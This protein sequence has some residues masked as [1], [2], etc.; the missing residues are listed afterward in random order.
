[1]A[2][3][4]S[5]NPGPSPETATAA[6]L[7]AIEQLE[8]AAGELESAIDA[9]ILAESQLDMVASDSAD[10]GWEQLDARALDALARVHRAPNGIDPASNGG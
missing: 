4:S 8:H 10:D 9:L 3:P 2:S 5:P 1:M 6:Y 7:A